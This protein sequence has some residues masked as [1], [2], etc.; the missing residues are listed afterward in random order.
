MVAASAW[1]SSRTPEPEPVS[2]TVPPSWVRDRS[3]TGWVVQPDRVLRDDLAER[4]PDVAGRLAGAVGG[5]PE[6]AGRVVAVPQHPPVEVG[7]GDQPPAGS[8]SAS[9]ASRFAASRSRVFAASLPATRNRS[10]TALAMIPS[11]AR[12]AA[13]PPLTTPH[14]HACLAQYPPRARGGGQRPGVRPA[15]MPVGRRSAC[16]DASLALGLSRCQRGG[17]VGGQF[18]AK[19]PGAGW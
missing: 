12:P 6:P 8:Y 4:V 2:H 13:F 9:A 18:L 7:L 1:M 10:F 11:A 19:P 14:P 17:V 3:S 16:A 15:P 5:P